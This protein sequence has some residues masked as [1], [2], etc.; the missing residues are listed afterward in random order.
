METRINFWF[1]ILDVSLLL[2]ISINLQRIYIL[3][4]KKDAK[5]REEDPK[6]VN[7]LQRSYKVKLNICT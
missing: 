1:E 6:K 2:A 3:R 5:V 7:D 4:K